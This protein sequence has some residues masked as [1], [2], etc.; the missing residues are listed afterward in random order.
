M[1]TKPVKPVLSKVDQ[2]LAARQNHHG[3][4]SNHAAAAQAMKEAFNNNLQHEL[5]P[6]QAEA[7]DMILH[8]LARIAAGDPFHEDHWDDIAGYATLV[9]QRC[10]EERSS[11]DSQ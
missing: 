10:A 2:I 5:T 4:F 6:V 8:K 1:A 7:V 3:D 9:S 11:A